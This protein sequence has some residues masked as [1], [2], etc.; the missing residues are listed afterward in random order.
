MSFCCP[1]T[2]HFQQKS[3]LFVWKLRSTVLSYHF[4]FLLSP[5]HPWFQ[6]PTHPPGCLW[7]AGPFPEY[8]IT[9]LQAFLHSFS[10]VQAYSSLSPL[11]VFCYTHQ[12][13]SMEVPNPN[14]T[15]TSPTHDPL[16][17]ESRNKEIC[18]F[19]FSHRCSAIFLELPVGYPIIFQWIRDS[20]LTSVD[21][22]SIVTFEPNMLDLLRN[23]T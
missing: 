3:S 13:A 20:I 7:S 14:T 10:E 1:L 21:F 11:L 19:S 6:A 18:R 4:S 17:Q 23:L 16:T 12:F 22:V 8:I 9:P 2:F 15:N 5:K